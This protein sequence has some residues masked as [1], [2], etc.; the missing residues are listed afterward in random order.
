M[1]FQTVPLLGAAPNR[2]TRCL[3]VVDSKLLIC[4]TLKCSQTAV[5]LDGLLV[6]DFQMWAIVWG[7]C[8]RWPPLTW[9]CTVTSYSSR[10]SYFTASKLL[11]YF[12]FCFLH[13][14]SMYWS[15]KSLASRVG[16][17]S[18]VSFTRS[19]LGAELEF[20][21]FS[22]KVDLLCFLRIRCKEIYVIVVIGRTVSYVP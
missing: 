14:A 8:G 22:F 17:R 6:A 13:R 4:E 7:L 10:L 15:Q 1:V 11:T 9:C 5:I 19:M 12:I 20:G 2:K 3:S 21:F 18:L 16:L